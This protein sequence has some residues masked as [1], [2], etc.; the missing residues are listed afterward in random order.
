VTQRSESGREVI[1]KTEDG[2]A[3]QTLIKKKVGGGATAS[4]A[5]PKHNIRFV[6]TRPVQAHKGIND[7]K[8]H[9]SQQGQGEFQISVVCF[10]N[11]PVVGQTLEQPDIKAHIIYKDSTGKEITDASG[12]VWLGEYGDETFFESGKKKCL[13]VFLLNK[14]GSLLKLWKEQYHTSTSWMARG[15][16]FRIRDEAM[17][18][19]VASVEISLLAGGSC[20]LKVEFRV[21]SKAAGDL[22]K[23]EL[24]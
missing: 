3:N 24:L 11:E 6:E 19:T 23:L 22:P 8:I 4:P 9:E 17:R 2:P 21:N 15:P 12:A 10:R 16:L 5:S 14:Q 7:D 13:I 20:V 18:G 1:L